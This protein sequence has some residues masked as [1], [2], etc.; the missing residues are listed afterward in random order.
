MIICEIIISI[1]NKTYMFKK[2]ILKIKYKP[3]A[4]LNEHANF[5]LTAILL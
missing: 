4:H 3:E 5:S 2:Y 1:K